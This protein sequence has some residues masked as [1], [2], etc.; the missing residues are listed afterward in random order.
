[1]RTV[2][3]QV[4][5]FSELS[6]SAKE[7][8]RDW[9]RE[10]YDFDP[11]YEPFETAARL[12]GIDLTEQRTNRKGK[13]YTA[14]TI[15]Y[16]GFS[17][18]GDGASFT[19]SYKFVPRC[20]DTIRENFGTDTRLWA[21]ADG[22]TALHNRLRL[23]QGGWLAGTITQEGRYVHKYTMDA[24]ATNDLDGEE[25]SIELSKEFLELMR[26]FAEWIYRGLEQE[27]DWR[28]SDECVDESMESNEYEFTEDGERA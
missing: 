6:D 7:K 22:L 25:L 20:C 15:Q 3:V 21:I 2:E 16:S 27:Y 5:K 4:F 1:M 9:Y 23:L 12:L 28:Q 13:T 24:T 14:N 8:A 10:G 18:Q 26:D 17:S 19:G 11:E